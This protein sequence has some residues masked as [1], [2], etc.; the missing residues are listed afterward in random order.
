MRFASV[1]SALLLFVIALVV[2]TRAGL[3]LR[4]WQPISR[5]LIWLVVVYSMLGVVANAITPSI[6]ERIIWLPV[7]IMLLV[8]SAVVAT[9]SN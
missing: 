6:W 5:K 2:L 9:K 7:A 3:V 4:K 1:L 8:C